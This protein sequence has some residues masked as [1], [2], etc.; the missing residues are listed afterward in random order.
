MASYRPRLSVPELP[1]N[2]NRDDVV[3][4]E[5]QPKKLGKPKLTT[6]ILLNG[7]NKLAKQCPMQIR[8]KDEVL[9]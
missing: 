8:G 1:A 5:Q 7:I 9:I 6:G 2:I 4:A 3:V